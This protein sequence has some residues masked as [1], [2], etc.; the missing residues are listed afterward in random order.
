LTTT[1]ENPKTP[2]IESAVAKIALTG[3]KRHVFFCTH[4]DCAP[5]EIGEASWK[6][7]K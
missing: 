3:A 1:D 7:L 2:T 4:G 5:K 6:Y